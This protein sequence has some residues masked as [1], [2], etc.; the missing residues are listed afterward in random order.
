MDDE[1][2]AREYGQLEARVEHL[3]SQ[4]LLMQED[5]RAMRHLL[6]QGK[7]GWRTLAWIGGA[8]MT[9]GASS[10]W[11]LDHLRWAIK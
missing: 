7:G 10:T 4:M 6:E 11:I 2:S 5:V 3:S 8:A 1:I 9:L